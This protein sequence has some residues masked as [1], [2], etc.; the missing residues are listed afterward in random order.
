MNEAIAKFR[1]EVTRSVW[2]DELRWGVRTNHENIRE[3][4]TTSGYSPDSSVLC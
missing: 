2:R 4:F 3:D 1:C